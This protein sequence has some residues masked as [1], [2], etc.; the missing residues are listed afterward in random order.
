MC[1]ALLRGCNSSRPE[2]RERMV[3]VTRLMEM[4]ACSLLAG[5]YRVRSSDISDVV[6]IGDL[7]PQRQLLVVNTD[8]VWVTRSRNR[9]GLAI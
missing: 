5:H 7:H 1:K 4:H 6:I 9:V 3:C 2:M 8:Q